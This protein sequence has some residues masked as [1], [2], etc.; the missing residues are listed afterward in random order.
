MTSFENK[1]ITINSNNVN[2]F[3]WNG[4]S[5]S[6]PTVSSFTLSGLTSGLS[7]SEYAAFAT[8]YGIIY[9]EKFTKRWWLI[10]PNSLS[11]NGPYT[12]N[13]P[14]DLNIYW[15]KW[16]SIKNNY[17][18]QSEPDY[19][20]CIAT[21]YV[22]GLEE[23][24]TINIDMRRNVDY[25]VI[26]SNVDTFIAND[27]GPLEQHITISTDC[28]LLSGSQT[29]NMNITIDKWALTTISAWQDGSVL[30]G[31][32]QDI[33]ISDVGIHYIKNAWTTPLPWQEK[34]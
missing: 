15:I 24:S 21:R 31:S 20:N 18:F 3:Q 7:S 5:G 19:F 2:V 25:G 11:S 22:G 13:I 10:N 8:S 33:V 32:P 14:D 12:F 4:V 34:Y 23:I 30:V 28:S 26:T 6:Q 1:F 27:C 9:V 16:P 29:T 17:W